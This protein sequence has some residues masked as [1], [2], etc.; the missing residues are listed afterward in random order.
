MF[1]AFRS[2][3]LLWPQICY[4]S[5]KWNISCVVCLI[6]QGRRF[7]NKIFLAVAILSQMAPPSPP[8]YPFS[9]HGELTQSRLRLPLV[10]G[11]LPLLLVSLFYFHC[12]AKIHILPIPLGLLRCPSKYFHSCPKWYFQCMAVY[13]L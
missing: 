8:L 9:S 10:L 13:F 4:P 6:H 5:H 11:S 3:I 1:L 12:A 7:F 2:S